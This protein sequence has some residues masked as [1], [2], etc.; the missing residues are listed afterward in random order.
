MLS[1]VATGR[2]FPKIAVLVHITAFF[3]VCAPSACR[4]TLT[5]VQRMKDLV[6]A[7]VLIAI[8]AFLFLDAF[9]GSDVS[10][11]TATFDADGKASSVIEQKFRVWPSTQQV[12]EF[13]DALV[14]TKLTKCAVWDAKHWACEDSAGS[15]VI[16]TNGNLKIFPTEPLVGS[17]LGSEYQ[18]STWA[19]WRYKIGEP[20]M[21]S[22]ASP[23]YFQAPQ[24]PAK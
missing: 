6:G 10:V 13:D 11:Y 9:T 16:M 4:F 1:L 8:A 21:R 24:S 18:V 14:V 3:R 7:V 20:P 12:V 19:W 17:I 2:K 15:S 23:I 22:G 5:P